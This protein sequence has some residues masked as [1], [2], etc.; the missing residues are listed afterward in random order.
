M[1]AIRD[2]YP[3][4]Y[5]GHPKLYFKAKPIFW[6]TKKWAH[7]RFI[8]RELTSVAVAW[9]A[10]LMIFMIRALRNGPDAYARFE[11]LMSNPF[12]IAFNVVALIFLVYHS[13]TWFNLAPKAMVVKIGT[14]KIPGYV[15]AG[16][17]YGAWIVISAAVLI[18]MLNG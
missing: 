12:L 10:L 16:M 17:N 18:F 6:W 7:M 14:S 13:I 15:I 9:F 8:L 11:H 4:Y 1:G 2:R 3:M 5:Q